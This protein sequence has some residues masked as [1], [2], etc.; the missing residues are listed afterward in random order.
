ML[1]KHKNNVVIASAGSRK[2]TFV[3]EDALGDKDKNV[4]IT[5]YTNE[6]VSQ[7]VDYIIE[8]NG[9]VPSNITVM[10]WFSFLL[11]DGVKPYQN[12]ILKNKK[13]QSIDFLNKPNFYTKKED[14]S[15]YINRASNIYR[16]NVSDFVCACNSKSKGLVVNRL[17]KIYDHIYVDEMQDLSGWDQNLIELLFDSSITVTLVGDPRQSTYYTTNSK[18]NK[19][20]KGQNMTDWVGELAKK[21]KCCLHE[22]VRCYRC[23]QVICDFADELYPALSKTQSVNKDLSGHDGIFMIKKEEVPEYI[24]K[25]RPKILRWNKS[26]D[27]LGLPSVNIGVTKGRSYDRVVVFTTGPMREYLKTKDLS[28]A[29]DLSKFYVAVTRARCSVTFVI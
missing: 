2:T 19:A 28:K 13:V 21:D 1:S 22:H 8:R 6:N 25:Y 23:N 7:I 20:T 4:L 24:K 9:C 15:Y 12:F 17:E 26:V 3:V 14:I 5:T 11:R 29:G 27:T 18:K 10:S 16:D